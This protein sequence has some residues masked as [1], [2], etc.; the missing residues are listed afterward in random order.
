MVFLC[1]SGCIA[2]SVFP[3]LF[4]YICIFVFLD[5]FF[6]AAYK[7]M[8]VFL[9]GTNDLYITRLTTSSNM[10][11]RTCASIFKNVC[12]HCINSAADP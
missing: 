11:T 2:G 7:K 9:H 1:P 5:Y 4:L 10:C 3:Q 8:Y 6:D 12:T